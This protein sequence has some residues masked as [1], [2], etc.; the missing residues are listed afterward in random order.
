MLTANNTNSHFFQKLR[1]T[2]GM[3]KFQHSIFAMPFALSMVLFASQGHPEPSQLILIVLCMVTARNAAMSFN[4][5]VDREI[6]AKNPRT[7][8]REIP[9]GVLSLKFARGFCFLNIILFIIFSSFFNNLTL[10]L[11]PFAIAIILGYSLTKRFTHVTQLFLGI[12][13][14][15][16]PIAA[17]IAI[18]GQVSLFACLIGLAVT[19][20]VAGFDLIYSTLDHDYDKANG[21]KNIVVKLGIAKALALSRFLHTLCL[22]LFVL[23]GIVFQVASLY[24]VGIAIMGLFLI[25]EQSLVKATD[26]SRVN[27][28]F[29][30]LNGFVS[31]IFLLTTLLVV[32]G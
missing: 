21:L 11:S 15:I 19:F 32:Y 16:A 17:W 6:D 24:F 29:F 27:A 5:I 12:S 7:Q 14:G 10:V 26:L 3:I 23:A 2:L 9:K 28:A 31:M 30:T 8:N 1:L 22:A 4:R 25:Y 20:W 13:L 18:T